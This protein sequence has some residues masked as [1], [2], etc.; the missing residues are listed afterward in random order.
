MK[1]IA[2]ITMGWDGDTYY[3][4]LKIDGKVVL[5]AYDRN[6]CVEEAS[7]LGA[8]IVESQKG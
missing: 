6:E 4:Q 8:E 1:Q 2:V 3:Y 5:N 7:R